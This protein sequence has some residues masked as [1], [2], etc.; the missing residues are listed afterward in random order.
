[1]AR[2]CSLSLS[3]EVHL[4]S[5]SHT[6]ERVIAGRTSGQFELGDKVTW[7]AR[8]LGFSRQLEVCITALNFP[9]HFRD[10]MTRGAFRAMRHDHYFNEINGVT[11]MRDEF[12][13]EVPYGF[14]GKIGDRLFLRK[15][16]RNLLLARN[17]FLKSK[18][19]E[20]EG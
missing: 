20:S 12:Y 2:C 7:E 4:G 6:G 18:A 15:Y 14:L 11:E 5:T 13:Y 16:M 3:A 19:E 17:A 9:I 1:M 8:H 10:E